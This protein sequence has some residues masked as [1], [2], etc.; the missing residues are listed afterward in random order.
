M[1]ATNLPQ[2]TEEQYAKLKAVTVISD[3]SINYS[4]IP[5]PLRSS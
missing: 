5:P 4:E 2:L 1:S 3:E